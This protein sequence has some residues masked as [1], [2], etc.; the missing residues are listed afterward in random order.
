M[1]TLT[2]P[3]QSEKR[4]WNR[5]YLLA[6]LLTTL[7]GMVMV[8]FN[9]TIPLH[10]DAQGLGVTV[11]GM[12]VSLGTVVT[13]IYRLF[14]AVLT[15]RIGRQKIS[16]LG[17]LILFAGNL[18]CALSLGL[19]LLVVGRILQML[20]FA[21]ISTCMSIII[22]DVVPHKQLGE[23]IGYSALGNSL[24]QAFTPALA[25]ALYGL[26]AFRSVMLFAAGLG[27]AGFVLSACFLGYEKRPL[28]QR[29]VREPAEEGGSSSVR[30]K[31][32]L[33]IEPAAL[34]ATVVSFGCSMAACSVSMYLTHYATSNGIANISVFFA[35]SA[36][37]MVVARLT[38]SKF[39]DRFSPLVSVIPGYSMLALSMFLLPVLVE[40]PVLLY[41]ASI[42]YGFG[43]GMAMPAVNAAAV[44]SAPP[45]RRSSASSTFL[46]AG[47]LAFIIGPTLWGGLIDRLGH[48]AVFRIAGAVVMVCLLYACFALRDRKRGK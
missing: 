19:P 46:L 48:P 38:T 37:A 40:H 25:L 4:L 45:E 16:C 5:Y 15:D 36:A 7:N 42:I 31:L 27:A 9:N 24:A 22:I 29:P 20:G 43:Q 11:S 39:S 21:I 34:K 6:I 44:R 26:G 28:Y 41:P 10:A 14:G 12:L 32:R 1:E 8:L 17:M 35:L 2:T 30:G 33:L 47:D 18:L 13:L 3:Q 23:A